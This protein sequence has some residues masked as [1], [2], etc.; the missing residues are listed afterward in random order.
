MRRRD[1]V[2]L[3]GGAVAAWPRLSFAQQLSDRVRRIG[4]LMPYT[5]DNPEDQQRVAAIKEALKHSGWIEGRNIQSQYRWYAGNADRARSMAKEL[6]DLKPDVILVGATPGLVALR[7]ETR[8]IPLVFAAV[9]DPIG[10][11]LV[12][13]LARPGGNA[14]GFT[15]FEFSV[16]TKLLE[17]LQQSR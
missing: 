14:T 4:V 15:F 3:I 8:S 6:V 10:L 11:G 12:E 2:T 5:E 9:T 1:L 7:Q 17:A 13:S 16:G